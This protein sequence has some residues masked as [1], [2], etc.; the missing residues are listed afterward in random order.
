MSVIDGERELVQAARERLDEWLFEARDEAYADVFEE[1]DAALSDAELRELDRIDSALSRR[2][3]DGLWGAD[4]YG[5][6]PG[7]PFGDDRPRVVPVY[8]PEIP[9]DAYPGEDSLAES[10]R[11]EFN[12]VLWQYCER[13]A[14]ALQDRLDEFAAADDA[15][16][17]E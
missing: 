5:V 1:P 2:D 13:V 6:V 12:D 15:S 17:E 4:R 11:E 14:A 10:T 7:E 9:D 8:H 3:G 16:S